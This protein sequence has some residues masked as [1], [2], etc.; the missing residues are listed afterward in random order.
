MRDIDP[1]NLYK[2]K[3]NVP[4]YNKDSFSSEPIYTNNVDLV[5]KSNLYKKDLLTFSKYPLSSDND[6][7]TNFGFA[8][9]T[10]VKPRVVP[11]SITFNSNNTASTSHRDTLSN[12]SFKKEKDYRMMRDQFIPMEQ[13]L[14]NKLTDKTYYVPQKN[15]GGHND[16]GFLYKKG[17]NGWYKDTNVGNEP[18]AEL[19]YD[20]Y[21]E[22]HNE[23][24]K[25]DAWKVNPLV[26]PQYNAWLA[27]RQRAELDARIRGNEE[28]GLLTFATIL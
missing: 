23:K 4:I 11:N 21:S 28:G 14:H 10:Y 12:V 16:T 5:N 24:N 8:K 2:K 6:M 15:Y 9:D 27:S 18:Y 7:L 20:D 1:N 25:F 13:P 17:N 26:A 22:L 19:S 3:D